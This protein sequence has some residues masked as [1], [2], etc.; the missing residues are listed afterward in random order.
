MIGCTRA[1]IDGRL[2]QQGGIAFKEPK[3][4]LMVGFCSLTPPCID[5]TD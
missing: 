2:R 5:L 4:S 3:S 1:A